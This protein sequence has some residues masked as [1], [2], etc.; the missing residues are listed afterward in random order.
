M[1][2]GWSHE[3]QSFG[4]GFGALYGIGHGMHVDLGSKLQRS[5]YGSGNARVCGLL[6]CP[7]ACWS[8]CPDGNSYWMQ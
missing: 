4:H 8:A 5:G 1:H 3:L 7:D 6:G 2:D